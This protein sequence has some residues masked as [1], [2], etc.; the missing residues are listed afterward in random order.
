MILHPRSMLF[1][2]YFGTLKAQATMQYRQP[3][4][5]PGGGLA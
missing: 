3:M 2:S 4:T 1:H 5:G